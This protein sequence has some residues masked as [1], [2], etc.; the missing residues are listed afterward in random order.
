MTVQLT[1]VLKG[2]GGDLDRA[3]SLF[4]AEPRDDGKR[5]DRVVQS[6]IRSTIANWELRPG[7]TIE[8]LGNEAAFDL[9]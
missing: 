8:I 2:T 4:D 3:E 5:L 1:I 6:W 9:L 7:D